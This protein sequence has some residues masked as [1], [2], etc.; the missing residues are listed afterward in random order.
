MRLILLSLLVFTF[1]QVKSQFNLN[2]RYK[3]SQFNVIKL[4]D[5]VYSPATPNI[6]DLTPNEAEVDPLDLVMDIYLPDA[7]TFNFKPAIVCAHGG[8]FV[9]GSKDNQDM[10]AFCDSL[11]RAGYVAITIQYRLGINLIDGKSPIRAVYRAI[12]DGRTAIRF[13]RANASNFGIDTNNIYMIG[14][15]AGAFI[16]LH[17]VYI[18]DTLEIPS[19]VQSYQWLFQNTPN[20]GPLENGLYLNHSGDCNGLVSLWGGLYDVDA[21]DQNEDTPVLLVHG[22]NDIIVYYDKNGPF[23]NLVPSF[24]DVYGSK[25][26]HERLDSLNINHETYFV[27]GEGHEFYGV[28][29]GNF[30]FNGPNDYWDTVYQKVNEFYY[31][32]HAPIS[33]FIDSPNGLN[34]QFI[35]QSSNATAHYWDFGDGSFSS[36]S[37]PQHQYAVTGNYIVTQYVQSKNLSWDSTSKMIQVVTNPTGLDEDSGL[38]IVKRMNSDNYIFTAPGAI[39]QCIVYDINGKL[40]SD[41]IIKNNSTK[42]QRFH[43]SVRLVHFVDWNETLKLY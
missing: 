41:S 32:I 28:T 4:S 14:S 16:G 38:K 36:N 23:L 5:V 3:S 24:P 20:I 31:K 21:I 27:D 35:D 37:S 33:G 1:T 10:V 42:L 2:D 9:A 40:L 22:K 8:G 13:L 7:D 29:N 18:N 17:N 15:S 30:G 6:G 39:G 34:H 26:I 43:E 12:Q 11:A 25:R 19:Q